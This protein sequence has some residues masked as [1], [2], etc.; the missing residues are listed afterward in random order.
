MMGTAFVNTTGF[1]ALRACA[2]QASVERITE[3]T[4]TLVWT[5][6][7]Q[8]SF[9][10]HYRPKGASFF[11]RRTVAHPRVDLH[12]LR[13]GTSYDARIVGPAVETL[14]SFST[15]VA[16]AAGDSTQSSATASDSSANAAA[17]LTELS[18]LEIRVGK[19][20]EC[21]PH[22]D[23][24]TLYV[25][26]VD[27]GEPEG[28]RTI[29][30]GLVNFVPL[31]DM[32]GRSVVVLCNLKP[33]TMRGVTSYGMLLCAS[34]EDHTKVD[35]LAP[36]E[37]APLGELVTFEGHRADP[38]DPGNRATKAFDRIADSLHTDDNGIAMFDQVP[39]ETS[40]G[41]CI[42]PKK[43]VGSVS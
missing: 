27:I 24:D 23:A 11:S 26:K 14:L 20:I 5:T 10:V 36:P 38:V 29:V 22:P 35:P 8:A 37:G 32:I 12:G 42:S 43:I 40:A 31:D 3:R 34:N 21:E 25:E 30:S 9:I 19:I 16:T 2:T 18:R 13:P 39:F 7:A 4:A 1:K 15:P 33:R 41:P 17:P 6:T 28:P